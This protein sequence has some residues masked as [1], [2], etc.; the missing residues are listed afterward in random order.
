M[1]RTAIEDTTSLEKA[2]R[3]AMS[4]EYLG[5]V[6]QIRSK[7]TLMPRESL[8]V[9]VTSSLSGEGVSTIAANLA[10]AA[11]LDDDARVLVIDA[12]MA[13][14][15]IGRSFGAKKGPGLADVLEGQ[16]CLDECIQ[17]GA[18][19]GRVSV[20]PAGLAENRKAAKLTSRSVRSVMDELA[21]TYSMIIWD[22]P[23]ASGRNA[24][25]AVAPSLS[26]VVLIVEAERV[27]REVL[28]EVKQRLEA[29]DAHLFGVV[30]NK[31]RFHLPEWLY[32]RL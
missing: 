10:L 11:A 8:S 28:Q 12:H 2:K 3:H 24:T 17:T 16:A 7:T 1:I 20:L 29:S 32:R 22:L 14:P 9:G 13:R 5:L 30:F 31:R 4:E 27:K 18:A 15:K 23:P 19:A 21:G 25:L 26:G 6:E